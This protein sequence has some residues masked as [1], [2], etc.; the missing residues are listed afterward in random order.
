MPGFGQHATMYGP[1]GDLVAWWTSQP[2]GSC[3]TPESVV[4]TEPNGP[5]SVYMALPQAQAQ[6]L[7][8][9][10]MR[11]THSS[12]AVTSDGPLLPLLL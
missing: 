6:A 3:I 8:K 4:T 12:L 10:S 7:G 2:R 1:V 9:R 11:M 5:S